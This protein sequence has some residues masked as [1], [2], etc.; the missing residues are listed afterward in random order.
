MHM[1]TLTRRLQVLLEEERFNRLEE[2]ARRRE[3]TVAQLARDALD[4]AYPPGGLPADVAADRFLARPPIDFG[5][6]EEAKEE[7][8]GGLARGLRT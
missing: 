8:E 5:T 6:W 3:T 7:I 2:L 1:A 4:R